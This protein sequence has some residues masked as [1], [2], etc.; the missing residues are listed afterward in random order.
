MAKPAPKV[1]A[2]RA[3]LVRDIDLFIDRLEAYQ[4]RRWR[5]YLGQQFKHRQRTKAAGK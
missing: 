3:R 5:E 1:S 2:A 4:N